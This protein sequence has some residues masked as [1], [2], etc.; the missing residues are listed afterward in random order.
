MIDQTN[1][2]EN[3]SQNFDEMGKNQLYTKEQ[4]TDFSKIEMFKINFK[5]CHIAISKN[6]G[7]IALCKQKDYYDITRSRI[8]DDIIVMHQDATNRY[9]IPIDWDYE[10]RYIVSLEFNEKEQLFAFCNDGTILKLDI[11]TQKAVEKPNSYKIKQEGICKAKLFEK[12]YIVLTEKGTI[13]LVENL[14]EPEAVFIISIKEQLGFTNDID[15][16]GIP[17]NKSFSGKFEIIITNQKGEG[18]LHIIRQ[19]PK[20]PNDNSN[21]V[22]IHEISNINI[23][24]SY[25]VTNYISFDKF[26][27]IK[28]VHPKNIPAVFIKEEVFKFSNPFIFTKLLHPLN[29]KFFF[30][31]FFFFF[32]SLFFFFFSFFF[33]FFL[34]NFHI[35]F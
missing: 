23:N 22:L 12:G 3:L 13:Y 35:N 16:I 33:F 15:F 28:L 4:I 10:A 18:V 1:N 19:E 21:I 11:L 25:N 26:K 7:L 30:S 32:F 14:K 17:P 9:F 20:D 34:F 5:L 8:N 24:N 2:L 29:K 27:E 31:F 6:G